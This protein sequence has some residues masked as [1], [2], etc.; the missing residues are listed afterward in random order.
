MISPG[1]RPVLARYV[2]HALTTQDC[3]ERRIDDGPHGNR[4]LSLLPVEPG[5]ESFVFE[6]VGFDPPRAYH[7]DIDAKARYLRRETPR[8]GHHSMFG[9]AVEPAGRECDRTRDGCNVHDV[10]AS[11][12][13]HAAKEAF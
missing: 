6:E 10:T 13:D 12:F 3:I 9:R 1:Q 11:S 2:P 8:P 5:L 4:H 7:R